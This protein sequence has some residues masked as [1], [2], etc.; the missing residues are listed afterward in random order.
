MKTEDFETAAAHVHRFLAID[1]T[2]LKLTARDD[3]QGINKRSSMTWFLLTELSL[4]APLLIV[5]WCFCMKPRTSCAGS[6]NKSLMKLLE[7]EMQPLSKDS[8]KSSLC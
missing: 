4:Q 3:T 5:L 8:S 7:T 1:E 6:L 2:T